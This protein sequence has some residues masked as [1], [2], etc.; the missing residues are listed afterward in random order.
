MTPVRAPRCRLLE[1]TSGVVFL[2]FLMAVTPLWTFAACTFQLALIAHASLIVRHSAD[3]AARSA[4]VVLPDDPAEYGGEPQMSVARHR[5]ELAGFLDSLPR[6]IP[7]STGRSGVESNHASGRG[8][9]AHLGRSRL[10][11]IRLAAHVPLLPLAGSLPFGMGNA[12]FEGALSSPESLA[13]ALLY[14]PLAV[15]VTFPGIEGDLATGPEVTVRVTYAFECRVPLARALLCRAFVD[16]SGQQGRRQV[17]LG[18]PAGLV[19][20]RFREIYHDART[21]V[22]QA[23]YEYRP[24]G[25]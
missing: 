21:L 3:A 22:Q 15:A 14:Q 2:E 4:A 13:S 23:P 7:G 1:D 24:R 20:G 6:S 17:P 10:N 11:T 16:L 5:V 25:S 9:V 19:R 8:P 12:S 18:A